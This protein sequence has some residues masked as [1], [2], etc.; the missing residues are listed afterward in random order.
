MWQ[1]IIQQCLGIYNNSLT[2]NVIK[3]L[4]INQYLSEERYSPSSGL[5]SNASL[6]SGQL[7]SEPTMKTSLSIVLS[8]SLPLYLYLSLTLSLSTSVSLSLSLPLYL[9]L[10]LPTSI[11]LSLPLYLYLSTSISLSLPL[12]LYLSTSISLSLSLYLCISLYI[13]LALGSIHLS[14]LRRAL[15]AMETY[16]IAKAHNKSKSLSADPSL[17]LHSPLHSFLSSRSLLPVDPSVYRSCDLL[18]L[19]LLLL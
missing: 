3:G 4:V 13:V 8:L 18:L 12:Y 19:I 2:L 17:G 9:S 10:S 6:S 16:C 1:Q 14:S 11:S 15:Q 7:Y 5:P